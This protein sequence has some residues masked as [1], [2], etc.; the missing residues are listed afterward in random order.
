VGALTAFVLAQEEE[1][2]EAKDLYPHAN[3][4]IVGAIAFAILF[5]FIWKWALPRLNQVLEQRRVK[6]QGDLEGAEQAKSE[7]QRILGR[8]E[9]QL[10][11]ARSEAGKIIEESRKTAEQ[12]RKDLLAKAEDESRQVVARAQEEIRAE[13]DRAFEQLRAQVGTLSVELASRVLGANLDAKAQERLVNEY[14]D[15]VAG[16]GGNGNG[17]G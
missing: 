2:N 16:M 10:K 1:I 13:R 11:D 9:E 8:Y 17:K 3:E 7:A 12:M 15:E 6:I 14:I 5:F 4:L